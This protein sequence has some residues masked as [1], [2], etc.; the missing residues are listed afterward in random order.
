MER[1]G[2]RYVMRTRNR[3]GRLGDYDV[4]WVIGGKRMQDAVTV[5]DTADTLPAASTARTW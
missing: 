1:R 5:F 4:A 2:D 3:E